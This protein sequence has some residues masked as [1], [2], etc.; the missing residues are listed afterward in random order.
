MSS[1]SGYDSLVGDE[2]LTVEYAEEIA[3]CSQDARNAAVTIVKPVVYVSPRL[4]QNYYQAEVAD[5]SFLIAPSLDTTKGIMHNFHITSH[6]LHMSVEQ[7]LLDQ[8]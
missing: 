6:F 1:V 4:D 3:K 7:L 5:V 2:I 8:S